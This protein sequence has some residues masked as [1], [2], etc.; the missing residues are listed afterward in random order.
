L[1]EFF[2]FFLKAVRRQSQPFTS[3]MTIFRPNPA[4]TPSPRSYDDDDDDDDDDSN[5]DGPLTKQILNLLDYFIVCYE[6]SMY[7][8][9]SLY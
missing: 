9:C 2:I 5:N 4:T 7:L 1:T 8:N 3:G 6:Y